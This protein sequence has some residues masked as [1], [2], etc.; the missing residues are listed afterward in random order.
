[1]LQIKAKPRSKGLGFIISMEG[2]IMGRKRKFVNKSGYPDWVIERVARCLYDDMVTDF[3][4]PE[5]QRDF[6]AW[7]AERQCKADSERSKRS[8]RSC[9]IAAF[10]IGGK[11]W[12]RQGGA[13]P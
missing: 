12:H 2:I 6:E 5:V 4:K 9:K 11:G 1:M 8:S 10:G 3:A 7:K 13:A